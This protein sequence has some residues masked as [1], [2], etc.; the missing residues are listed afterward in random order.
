MKRGREECGAGAN[1]RSDDVRTLEPE[2]VGDAYDE[3]THRPRREQTLATLR[4]PEPRK[5]HGNE[6]CVLRQT[7]PRRLEREQAFGPRIAP[8]AFIA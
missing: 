8:L 4:M 7:R 5:V 6:M 1:V 2:R 3:L